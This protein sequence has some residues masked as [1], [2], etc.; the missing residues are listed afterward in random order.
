MIAVGVVVGVVNGWFVAKAK[1]N[2]FMVTLAMLILLRGLTIGLTNGK[3]LYNL[4]PAFTYLGS[5]DWFGVPAAVWLAG[6]LFLVVGLFLRYHRFG[7]AIY[8]VGG[9]AE[10]AR[11][12]GIR[13]ETVVWIVYI[14]GC[15][16]AAFAG[17]LLT[18]RSGVGALRPGSEH[19]LHRVRRV[20]IGGISLSGGR[21]SMFGA[22]TGVLLL[23]VISNILTLS[24]IQPFWID[25]AF[26]GVI[27]VALILAKLTPGRRRR[28]EERR[29]DGDGQLTPVDP[30]LEPC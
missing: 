19:D 1:L 7:R 10:A 29:N 25:A 4:P 24:Q 30:Q 6:I 3:T 14:V 15:G 12:A 13:V 26:G 21:G 5:T 28:P 2:A 9:N 23:G 18:G 17:L 27:L 22:L 20:V 11:A 8:A 16:L